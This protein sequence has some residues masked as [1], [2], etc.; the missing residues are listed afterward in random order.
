MNADQFSAALF[1]HVFAFLI[2]DQPEEW[3]VCM[4]VIELLSKLSGESQTLLVNQSEP[5]RKNWVMAIAIISNGHW[6]IPPS[7]KMISSISI[8]RW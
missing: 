6:S 3:L 5:S 8:L 7:F 4:L 2:A 1:F